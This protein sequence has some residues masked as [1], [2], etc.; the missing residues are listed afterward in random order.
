M[1]V[2]VRSVR[3]LARDVGLNEELIDRN[4]EALCD[5]TWRVAKRERKYCSNR[6][7]GWVLS[8][9]LIKPPL[10]ELLKEEDEEEYDF[11]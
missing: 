5:F 4:I 6:V 2:K 1:I 10:V 3:Q 7:R 8:N 9:E 11:I